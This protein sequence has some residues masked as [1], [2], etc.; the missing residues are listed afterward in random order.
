MGATSVRELACS[1]QR[2]TLQKGCHGRPIYAIARLGRSCGQLKI[3]SWTTS[4]ICQNWCMSLPSYRGLT[5]RNRLLES[6]SRFA[7]SQSPTCRTSSDSA[8]RCSRIIDPYARCLGSPDQRWLCNNKNRL[9]RAAR[10]ME[11]ISPSQNATAAIDNA[12][13]AALY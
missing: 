5:S 7:K 2:V 13:S 10:R 3:S 4:L 8:F 1:Y 12:A 9:R 6:W 11:F